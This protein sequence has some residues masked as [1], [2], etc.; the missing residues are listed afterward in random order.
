M[1]QDVIVG[2]AL[3]LIGGAFSLWGHRIVQA[4]I[5]VWGFIIGFPIGAGFAGLLSNDA[6]LTWAGGIIAGVV[7]AVLSVLFLKWAIIISGGLI[8]YGIGRNLAAF[9]GYES[10]GAL[11]TGGLIVAALLILL[12]VV[13]NAKKIYLAIITSVFGASVA[14]TGLLVLIGKIPSEGI[15]RLTDH[16]VLLGPFWAV[17]YVAWAIAAIAFQLKDSKRSGSRQGQ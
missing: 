1:S 2:F 15:N 4:A 8:G 9:F 3:L 10:S 5:A 17:V 11:L 13:F 12:F 7:F 14:L 6:A 16:T